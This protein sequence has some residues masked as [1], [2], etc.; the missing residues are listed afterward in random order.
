MNRHEKHIHNQCKK[1]GKMALVARYKFAGYLPEVFR[2]R[3]YEKAGFN[4]VFEY[5]AKL[6]GFSEEQVRRVLNLDKK[7]EDKPALQGLLREGKVSVNKL[8]RVA[9]IATIENQE[10]LAEKVQILPNRAIETFVRDEKNATQDELQKPL[11]EDKSVHVHTNSPDIST[12]VKLLENLDEEVK[13]KLLKLLEKGVNINE[14]LKTFLEKREE[15][16][17]EHTGSQ[18]IRTTSDTYLFAMAVKSSAL[19]DLQS[20]MLGGGSVREFLAQRAKRPS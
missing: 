5:A 13:Q 10:H 2:L 12:A 18:I 4:S 8:A 3:I 9:S 6:A 16:I 15:E 1:Y 19:L 20:G 14:E 11:F 7:F 17:E